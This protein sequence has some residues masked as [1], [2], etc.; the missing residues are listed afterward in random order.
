VIDLHSHILPGIDDG[1]TDLSVSVAMA[2]AWV[3][4]GVTTVA[5]TPHILP[6]LYH[7]TGPQIKQAVLRL[8]G[9]LDQRGIALKLVSGADVHVVP[10]FVAGLRSGR[11]LSLADSR[12]VLVEPPHHVPPPRLDDL[13]FQLIVAG[14]VPVVTH[15]ERLSWIKTHFATFQNLVRSGVW[16]QITAGSL[17]G[18]FGTGPRYWAERMLDEGYVHILATD[19]HDTGR[20]AP[21]LRQGREIAAKRVGDT[22]A[23]HLVQTRPFGIIGNVSPSALPVPTPAVGSTEVA[24]AQ[25]GS[26]TKARRGRADGGEIQQP[27]PGDRGGGLA[28]RLRRF[29]R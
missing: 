29:F 8:Q 21:N 22:E 11:L 15:P 13:M 27:D 9:E 10:D 7:N 26:H 4:D 18:N 23:E 20:R 5:C 2:Q 12:Y 14:Y 3:A 24:Y 19:A 1:A 28:E 16:M 17:S 6:G 25:A